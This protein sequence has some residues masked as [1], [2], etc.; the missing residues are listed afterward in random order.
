MK[1]LRRK[2]QIYDSSS[3]KRESTNSKA[4]NVRLGRVQRNELHL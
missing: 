3:I 4:L 1:N 2:L